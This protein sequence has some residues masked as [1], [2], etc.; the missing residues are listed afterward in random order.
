[1]LFRIV[2][3]YGYKQQYSRQ[4]ENILEKRT[5]MVAGASGTLGTEIVRAL[6]EKGAQ[7]RA[8]SGPRAIAQNSNHSG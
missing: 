4:K 1:M 5:V 6:L 3:F 8:W 2:A 7:V